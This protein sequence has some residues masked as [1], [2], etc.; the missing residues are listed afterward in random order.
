MRWYRRAAEQ[1]NKFAQ[2]ALG[3]AYYMGQGVIQDL[4]YSHMWFNI[5]ASKGYVLAR[6]RRDGVATFMTSDQFAEAQKLARE[7]V[8]KQYKDC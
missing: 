8:R 6:D 4:V 7:C 5:A 1:G 2:V 3:E